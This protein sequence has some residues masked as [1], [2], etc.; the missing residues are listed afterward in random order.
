MKQVVTIVNVVKAMAQ[1]VVKVVAEVVVIRN[2]KRRRE[3]QK[4][5]EKIENIGKMQI[6]RKHGKSTIKN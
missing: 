5:K 2:E 6:I 3:I 1:V 4:R